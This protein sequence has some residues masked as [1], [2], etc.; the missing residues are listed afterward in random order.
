MLNGLARMAF[1]FTEPEMYKL[2]EW[3]PYIPKRHY[4]GEDTFSLK[5]RWQL[6]AGRVTLNIASFTDCTNIVL[7]TQLKKKGGLWILKPLKI[8]S[9]NGLYLGTL[10]AYRGSEIISETEFTIHIAPGNIGGKHPR[11]WFDSESKTWLDERLKSEKFKNVYESISEN[12]AKQRKS[13]TL[14]S[15]AF[16]L[17]QFPDERWLPTWSP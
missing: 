2:S 4:T 3:K 6:D 1:Q 5:G 7:S 17:D 8:D 9:P 10:R 13:V 12:A 11:L 16:D 14:E 15:L